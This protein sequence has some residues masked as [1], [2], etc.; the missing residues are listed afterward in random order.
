MRHRDAGVHGEA[1]DLVEHR[2]VG[3]VQRVGAERAARA[4]DIDGQF[5]LQ[6][7]PDLHRRGVGAQ[8]ELLVASFSPR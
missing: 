2:R 8:D 1:L 5:A 7:R 3:G 6:Q 4:H